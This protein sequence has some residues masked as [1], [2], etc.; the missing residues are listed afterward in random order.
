M[1][2]TKGIG[3]KILS[4][5]KVQFIASRISEDIQSQVLNVAVSRVGADFQSQVLNITVSRIQGDVQSQA[6]DM[7]VGRIQSE[8]TVSF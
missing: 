2:L 3:G 6:L 4:F 8:F 5:V 1:L 7:M